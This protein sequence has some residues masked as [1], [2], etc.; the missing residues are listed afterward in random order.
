[1]NEKPSPI[2]ICGNGTIHILSG[3]GRC[4]CCLTA[5]FLVV[6][7]KGDSEGTTEV[8]CQKCNRKFS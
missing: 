7:L 4:D 5:Q 3:D 8:K 6:S 1:M 2:L